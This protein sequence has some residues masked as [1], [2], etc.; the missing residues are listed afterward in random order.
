MVWPRK[1]LNELF[2]WYAAQNEKISV[3][4]IRC[5]EDTSKTR[6]DK[7]FRWKCCMTYLKY[8]SH[9]ALLLKKNVRQKGKEIL[10]NC[11]TST[12]KEKSIF[13]VGN[14]IQRSSCCGLAYRTF[15]GSWWTGPWLLVYCC[16]E[17][18]K[19]DVRRPAVFFWYPDRT[20]VFD[21]QSRPPDMR[22]GEV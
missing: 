21:S 3:I 12:P 11:W 17:Q 9:K 16:L 2:T 4:L 18:W 6:Q 7:K 15:S 1:G 14:K 13:S 10:Q 5:N 19:Q 22:A 20:M 8:Q